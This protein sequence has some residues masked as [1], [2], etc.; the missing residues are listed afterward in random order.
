[1]HRYVPQPDATPTVENAPGADTWIAL[2]EAA[3]C[4]LLDQGKIGVSMEFRLRRTGGAGGA[5]SGTIT[6]RIET[7]AENRPSGQLVHADAA[8][9]FDASVVGTAGAWHV[10]PFP[11]PALPY[12]PPHHRLW[13][14]LKWSPDSGSNGIDLSQETGGGTRAGWLLTRGE[15]R[16]E[17]TGTSKFITLTPVLGLGGDGF[18]SRPP[19]F[20]LAAWGSLNWWV[21]AQLLAG[22]DR[23]GD[24]PTSYRAFCRFDLSAITSAGLTDARLRLHVEPS[25]L[26]T[27]NST[28]TVEEIDDFG[29]LAASHWDQPVRASVGATG[30][31]ED[32]WLAFD[33]TSRVVAA[34]AAGLGAIAFRWRTTQ[35]GLDAGNQVVRVGSA[36]AEHMKRGPRLVLTYTA[37]PDA[38]VR[39]HCLQKQGV[40]S[41]NFNTDYA[42]TRSGHLLHVFTFGGNVGDL[43]IAAL[44]VGGFDNLAGNFAQGTSFA[45]LIYDILRSRCEV[46]VGRLDTAGFQAAHDALA[47]WFAPAGQVDQPAPAST[48]LARIAAAAKGLIY[49]DQDGKFTLWVDHRQAAPVRRVRPWE[50]GGLTVRRSD[51]GDDP[52]LARPW[53]RVDVYGGFDALG[54]MNHPR[55][56]LHLSHLTEFNEYAVISADV[57]VPP[58]PD[59]QAQAALLKARYGERGNGPP[60]MT[61]AAAAPRPDIAV[62]PSLRPGQ[63]GGGLRESFPQGGPMSGPPTMGSGITATGATRSPVGFPLPRG[64]AASPAAEPFFLP[65]QVLDASTFHFAPYGTHFLRAV[66]MLRDWLWLQNLTAPA[67]GDVLDVALPRFALGWRLMD[68][69]E[70]ESWDVPSEA[71]MALLGEPRLQVG[72]IEG[73]TVSLYSARRA[74]CS[75]RQ[76][77]FDTAAPFPVTVTGRVIGWTT[78]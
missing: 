22:S 60:G 57:T 48:W 23:P 64:R 74:L 43:Q 46:P 39:L 69:V 24:V 47:T 3:R 29:T 58:D 33:V 50:V 14:V 72:T 54:L 5:P 1:M 67:V 37:G 9:E 51:A 38:Y 77:A 32:T 73:G 4:V 30:A 31:I 26:S 41:E 21:S 36:D 2:T 7:D 13:A 62:Y 8:V 76:L 17:W 40:V 6:L 66:R 70:I 63:F 53:S 18:L 44:M 19:L 71:A 49:Q 45:E 12:L 20:G 15:A 56:L 16:E 25:P 42:T 35:E 11:G 68:E 55:P 28:T 61:A 10:F 34:K 75:V 27:P 59:R 52:V 65:G 78:S